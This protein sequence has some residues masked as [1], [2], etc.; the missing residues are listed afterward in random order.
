MTPLEVV[1]AALEAG[2]TAGL[3][4]TAKEGVVDAYDSLRNVIRARLE[5][6]GSIN[7]QLASGESEADSL[8]REMEL[9]K[10]H[11][12]PSVLEAAQDLLALYDPTGTS[13]G[14]YAI[15]AEQIR[16]VYQGDSSFTTETNYGAMGTFNAPVSFS[17]SGPNRPSPPET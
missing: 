8:A 12:D 7:P 13:G 14:K 4:A 10:V 16:S 15:S 17:N 5:N 6:R 9:H 1:I 11:E 2:A 3:T